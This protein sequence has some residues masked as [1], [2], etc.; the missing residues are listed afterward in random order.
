M[1]TD[2]RLDPLCEANSAEKLADAIH[3]SS[4]ASCRPTDTYVVEKLSNRVPALMDRLK[5]AGRNNRWTA[6]MDEA[7]GALHEEGVSIGSI[8]E[9]MRSIVI[10]PAIK[11]SMIRMA[12]G[13]ADIRVLSDANNL[14]IDW[15]LEV[16][17]LKNRK[18]QHAGQ[19]RTVN[20]LVSEGRHEMTVFDSCFSGKWPGQGCDNGVEQPCRD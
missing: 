1:F 6:G 2:T 12:Q 15:I 20:T 13:G 8:K 5:D 9:C 14:F 10:D 3:L 4:E 16:L 18:E 19:S 17:L 7:M 11:E